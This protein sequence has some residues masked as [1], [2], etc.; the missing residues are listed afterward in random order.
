MRIRFKKACVFAGHRRV[1]GM[2][3]NARHKEAM[4]LIE[5]GLAEPYLG[6]YPPRKKMK[7]NLNELK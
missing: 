1:V 7:I 3:T 4:D 5:R 6:E 2:H